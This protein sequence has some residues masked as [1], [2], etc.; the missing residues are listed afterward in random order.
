MTDAERHMMCFEADMDL[1][2][3][4]DAKK[5]IEHY[6]KKIE[7]LQERADKTTQELNPDK[8]FLQNNEATRENIILTILDMQNDL[9]HKML[10]AEK[11]CRSLENKIDVWT[12]GIGARVLRSYYLY[13]QNLKQIAVEEGYSYKQ[14]KRFRWAALEQY[15]KNLT[16]NC[17]IGG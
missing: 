9:W 16:K 4:R 3:Y 8:I 1:R 6:R 2:Q 15:G 11:L 7:R 17:E 13:G 5:N 10:E 12:E 14:I